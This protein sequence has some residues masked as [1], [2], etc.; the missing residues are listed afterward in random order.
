MFIV[1][2]MKTNKYETEGFCRHWLKIENQILFVF[3]VK[4]DCKFWALKSY[5]SFFIS[6]KKLSILRVTFTNLR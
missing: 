1:M 3:P 2:M 6:E 4:N 5:R